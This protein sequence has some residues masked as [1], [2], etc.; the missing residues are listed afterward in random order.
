MPATPP[1]GVGVDVGGTKMLA[2]GLDGDGGVVAEHRT[3]TPTEAGE[4]LDAIGEAVAAV[5]A[6]D[7]EP[8]AIGVGVP[9]LV[10]Q[11]GVLQFSPHLPSLNGLYLEE[12]LRKR[13]P[14]AAVWVGNDATAAV[15]GE[16]VA[17]AA[18]GS[19]DV[20][21]VTLGTGIGGGIVLGGRL[22]EGRHRYAGELG[23]MVVDPHGPPCPC[24]GQGCWERYASGSGLGQLGR[25]AALSG[26]APGVVT[27]AGGDPE[28]VRGEH[29]TVAAAEGDPDARLI[30]VRFAWWLALGLANLANLL[31]PGA[32]VIGG[33]V[34]EAGEILMEPLREAFLE[35][36]EAPALREVSILPAQLGAAAGAVGAGLL[37]RQP[38]L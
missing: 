9:G 7:G 29:V 2:V 11:A 37:A 10:D 25:E 5:C 19:S 1:A 20:L 27:R 26:R 22:V 18:R 21:M 35:L 28:A 4:F 3:P 17:G 31:D 6:P 13:W 32:I 12:A 30:M 38:R 8:A 14:G 16:H 15:W 24:G 34:V 33:G 23:H 36:V